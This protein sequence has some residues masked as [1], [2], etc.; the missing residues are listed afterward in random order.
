MGTRMGGY[1]KEGL[2]GY[3]NGRADGLVD[4]C[5]KDTCMYGYLEEW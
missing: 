2:N 5:M 1:L 3:V 4:T